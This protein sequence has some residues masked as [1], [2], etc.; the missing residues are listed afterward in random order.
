[1]ASETTTFEPT[2]TTIIEPIR[3]IVFQDCG[4]WVAQCLEHDIGAQADDIDTLG[5]R[6]IVTLKAEV[7]E[8]IAR[9]TQPFAGIP[10]A[11]ERFHLM[12][13]RRVRSLPAPW[14]RDRHKPMNVDFGLVA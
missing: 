6:L 7:N 14:M 10:P 1:M 4:K 9:K 3:V 2:E 5:D 12:W 13:E 8:A 11:P